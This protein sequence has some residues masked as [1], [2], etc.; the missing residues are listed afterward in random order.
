MARDG[1]L[2][3]HNKKRVS[4]IKDDRLVKRPQ[5]TF[6]RFLKER[7]ASGDFKGIKLSEAT[8]LIAREF[9]GLTDSEK[10]VSSWSSTE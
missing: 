10:K 8:G 4:R 7:H 1:L 2:Q 6:S 9:K 5:N 3:R